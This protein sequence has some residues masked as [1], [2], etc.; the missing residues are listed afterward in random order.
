M[1]VLTYG[2]QVTMQW[3]NGVS[4]KCAL[5]AVTDVSTGD[6]I[7]LAPDFSVCNQVAFLG[8]TPNQVLEAPSIAGTV[9]TMPAGLTAEAGYMLV[10]GEAL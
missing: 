7:S 2:T 8:V 10:Y 6:T 4:D 1:A 9:V 5:Y 3:A